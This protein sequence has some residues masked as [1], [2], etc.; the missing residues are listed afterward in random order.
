MSCCLRSVIK[1]CLYSFMVT[2][3]R[4]SC[5]CHAELPALA[6]KRKYTQLSNYTAV[7]LENTILMQ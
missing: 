1:Y 3:I 7:E 4:S 6:R 2:D 5:F